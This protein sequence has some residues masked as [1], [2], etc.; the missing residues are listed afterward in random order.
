MKFVLERAMYIYFLSTIWGDYIRHY[1]FNM[2]YQ[3]H[4][5]QV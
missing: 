1:V 2:Y 4:S 3:N 5:V